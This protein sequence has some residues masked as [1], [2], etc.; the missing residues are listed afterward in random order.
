MIEKL[1]RNPEIVLN[2][3]LMKNYNLR[4]EGLASL[5]DLFP[6]EKYCIFLL[7]SIFKDHKQTQSKLEIQF[8]LNSIEKSDPIEFL[9]KADREGIGLTDKEK[10]MLGESMKRELVFKLQKKLG[11]L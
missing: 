11:E 2:L 4:P 9:P 10:R 5:D 7:D 3:Y 8:Y 6:E 1:E